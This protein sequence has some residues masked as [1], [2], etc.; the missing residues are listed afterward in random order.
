MCW[1]IEGGHYL[2]S[3]SYTLKE[4][5]ETVTLQFKPTP[6][7]PCQKCLLDLDEKTFGV[8]RTK[9][10]SLLYFIPHTRSCVRFSTP[11]QRVREATV[12]GGPM[13]ELNNDIIFIMQFLYAGKRDEGHDTQDFAS[14]PCLALVDNIWTKKFL[15]K[16]INIHGSI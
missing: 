10:I 1:R 16:F 8:R 6:E 15:P 5:K 9:D 4:E 7:T 12:F 2:K 14:F 13:S 3:C 11:T